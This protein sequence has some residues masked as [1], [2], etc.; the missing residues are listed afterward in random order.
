MGFF[1]IGGFV[2]CDEVEVEEDDIFVVKFGTLSNFIKWECKI[3]SR[4]KI[5]D[6]KR[7][8]W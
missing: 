4:F 3:S 1:K 5:C 7:W 6:E 8:N 2:D